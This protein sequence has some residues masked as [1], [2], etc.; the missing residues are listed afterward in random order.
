MPNNC[1]C[2]NC[3]NGAN[4]QQF[5]GSKFFNPCSGLGVFIVG[6]VACCGRLQKDQQQTDKQTQRTLHGHCTGA[7]L[8]TGNFAQWGNANMRFVSRR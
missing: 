2:S 4:F 8:V 6:I 1:D 5:F 7:C 3:S